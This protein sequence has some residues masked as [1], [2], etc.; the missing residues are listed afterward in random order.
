MLM[1][2]EGFPGHWLD[3]AFAPVL[4]FAERLSQHLR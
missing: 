3:V 1:V 2:G 4:H